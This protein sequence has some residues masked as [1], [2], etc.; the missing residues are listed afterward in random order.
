MAIPVK[1]Q[2]T[3]LQEILNEIVTDSKTG[4]AI[5]E[6]SA[7]RDVF[8]NPLADQVY[9]TNILADF[10]S[11]S[12][13]VTEMIRVVTDPQYID[14]LRYSLNLTFAEVQLFISNVVDNLC[15]NYNIVRSDAV[16]SRGYVRMY[17][18]APTSITIITPLQF[19]TKFGIKFQTTNSFVNYIPTYDSATGLYY[20]DSAIE[21]T[22]A[23]TVGNVEIGS[24]TT[25]NTAYGNLT[26]V[27]NLNR[28]KFGKDKETDL[29]VLNKTINALVSRDSSVLGGLLRKVRNYPGVLDAVAVTRN[30]IDSM[31]LEKNAV[32]V[33]ILAEEKSQ[34]KEDIFNSQSAQ[35]AWN[36]INN[37]IDFEIYP[38]SFDS[39]N[40]TNYKLLSQPAIELSSVSVSNIV[41]GSFSLIT[42][43]L[44]KDNSSVYRYSVKGNDYVRIPNNLLPSPLS[45]VKIN[46]IYDRMYKDLQNLTSSYENSGIGADI[47]YK[48]GQEKFV[49]MNIEFSLLPGYN[50]D[51]VTNN[52][53]FNLNQFFIGGQTTNGIVYVLKKLGENAQKSDILNVILDTEGVDD[54]N[55]ETFQVFI[56]AVEILRASKIK[57]YE[58]LRLGQLNF[59][60]KAL[61]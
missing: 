49:D 35:Y 27:I 47:L 9:D 26:R 14:A 60:Q 43:D 3:I 42:G 23:G 16:K 32:D 57:L 2:E 41:N 34:T 13:S 39:T 6:N 8:I 50:F 37:E 7:A 53:S 25:I 40:Y 55:I 52:I 22:V 46:Y 38:V 28:T 33:Y 17:F 29:E 45:W 19:S 54:V 4:L 61:T 5:Y 11:R 12:G 31:R 30:D 10:V 51:T 18:S 24:I 48:K 20:A 59:L 15:A 1:T 21:A 56:D 58:Y 36:S 44:I